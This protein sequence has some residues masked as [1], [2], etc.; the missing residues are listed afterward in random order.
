MRAH[1]DQSF[2]HGLFSSF[3]EIV[4]G[5]DCHRVPEGDES[6]VGLLILGAQDSEYNRPRPFL[7]RPHRD[8]WR[9]IITIWTPNSRQMSVDSNGV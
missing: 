9:E 8:R 4:E 6:L 7:G 1:G 5:L 2:R 3:I